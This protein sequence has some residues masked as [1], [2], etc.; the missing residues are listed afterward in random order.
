VNWQP[1]Y[2]APKDGRRIEVAWI[3]NPP[4]IEDIRRTYW[5]GR[6]GGRWFGNWT[7]TH[8]RPLRAADKPSA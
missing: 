1:I 6:D 3:V 2:T 4:T 5:V 8:W 7:P